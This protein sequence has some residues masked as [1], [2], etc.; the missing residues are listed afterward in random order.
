MP[1][2]NPEQQ[3]AHAARERERR[4]GE[5]PE[6]RKKRL[7]YLTAYRERNREL[8]AAKQRE[9]YRRTRSY[10]LARQAE[11]RLGK[12]DE[13]AA[14]QR[15]R[16]HG[17]DIDAWF[18]AQ[19]KLQAGCCYLCGGNFGDLRPHVDHDHS[20]CTAHRS[21]RVCRRGLACDRCNKL[22]GHID[23]DPDLLRLIADNLARVLGPTRERIAAKQAEVQALF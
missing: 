14:R 7:A 8:L 4:A 12:E 2:L 23:D 18:A 3:V 22:I 15:T 6:Q 9:R 17:P 10:Q 16:N 11:W 5:T 1:K 13:L 20:C 19:W 21:C